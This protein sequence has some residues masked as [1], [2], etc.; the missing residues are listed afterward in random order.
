MQYWYLRVAPCKGG[1]Y[2]VFYKSPINLLKIN[3]AKNAVIDGDLHPNFLPYVD[4]VEEIS[5]EKYYENMYD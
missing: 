1:E 4:I 3:V 2:D 5:K